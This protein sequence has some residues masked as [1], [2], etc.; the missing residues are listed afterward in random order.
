MVCMRDMQLQKKY[1][2][3]LASTLNMDGSA[4]SDKY[5]AVSR[6]KGMNMHGGWERWEWGI[7]KWSW[8]QFQSQSPCFTLH[9]T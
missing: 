5:D 9:S 2:V 3:A 6:W 4:A 8:P 7:G 1:Q